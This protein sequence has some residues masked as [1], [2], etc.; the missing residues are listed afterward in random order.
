MEKCYIKTND[1]TTVK[2]LV[3]LEEQLT[4]EAQGVEG[5]IKLE[6]L[7]LEKTSRRLFRSWWWSEAVVI[8]IM[9]SR[10]YIELSVKR[11]KEIAAKKKF[12]N[13]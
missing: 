5:V 9:P 12:K 11:V 7:G 6:E 4:V 1:I 13:T 10:W 2:V 8:R 3:V